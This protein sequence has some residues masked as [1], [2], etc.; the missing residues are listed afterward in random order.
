MIGGIGRLLNGNNFIE[1][2]GSFPWV[3][4]GNKKQKNDVSMNDGSEWW[5]IIDLI[6]KALIK[7]HVDTTACTQRGN[8]LNDVIFL[9]TYV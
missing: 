6:D 1:V 7:Y 4:T 2:A 8:I 3:R 9:V 5:R